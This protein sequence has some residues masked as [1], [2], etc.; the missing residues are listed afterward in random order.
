MFR[1]ILARVVSAVVVALVIAGVPAS[2]FGAGRAAGEC[3]DVRPGVAPIVDRV[4]L[5]GVPKG[6]CYG[7][8]DKDHEGWHD[9]CS[10][11]S[12][13][14]KK[15]GSVVSFK[16]PC[17]LHD[18]C[19]EYG[20]G[21]NRA[22][23]DSMLR[24]YLE[25]NCVQ[26]VRDGKTPA[27]LRSLATHLCKGRAEIMYAGIRIYTWAAEPSYKR[28]PWLFVLRASGGSVSLRLW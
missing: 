28:G 20:W 4:G 14:W 25:R 10:Y 11:S 16:G 18:M 5:V 21:S 7:P 27:F 19:L 26:S 8:A 13:T 9:Y 17:A 15:A 23:C 22:S 24:V 6:Y 2:G 3:A 1:R 12:D